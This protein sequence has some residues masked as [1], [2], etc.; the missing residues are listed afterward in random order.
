MPTTPR[1]RRVFTRRNAL[2]AVV[3]VAVLAIVVSLLS[4]LAYRNGVLDTY[5][6]TQFTSKMADIGIVFSA[7]V[8]R[9]TLNPLELELQN[10]TFNDKVTGEK[11]FFIRNASS[12]DDGAGSLLLAAQP[13]YLDRQ[14]RYQ[15]C[16]GLGE[17]R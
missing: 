3:A 1:R 4:L 13:R 17:V 5:V 6:K 9:V 16:R 15:R 14:H 7:D 11:L 10:A 8:F 2:F 12:L